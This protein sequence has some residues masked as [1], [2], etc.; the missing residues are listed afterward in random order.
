MGKAIAVPAAAGTTQTWTT[1]RRKK[2]KYDSNRLFVGN[3]PFSTSS[4]D[5]RARFGQFGDLAD[6][7]IPVF[8]TIG[9]SKRFAFVSF[10]KRDDALQALNLLNNRFL[11][12]RSMQISAAIQCLSNGPPETKDRQRNSNPKANGSTIQTHAP[13]L[14][15]TIRVN[16]ILVN[17]SSITNR[18]GS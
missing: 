16:E 11:G 3:I 9:R 7:Y 14:Q 10:S 5:L 18:Q 4:D 12:C 1:V 2:S 13:I 17:G 15:P 6:V 8:S